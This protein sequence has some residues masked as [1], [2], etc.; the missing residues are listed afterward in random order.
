MFLHSVTLPS[1]ASARVGADCEHASNLLLLQL[2]IDQDRIPGLISDRL[3]LFDLC[4]IA[5]R[6]PHR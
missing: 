6:H 1:A 5:C 4:S 2:V 3:L